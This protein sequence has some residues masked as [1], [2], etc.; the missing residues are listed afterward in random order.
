MKNR[1][2]AYISASLFFLVIGLLPYI[3]VRQDVMFL[4]PIRDILPEPLTPDETVIC[5]RFLNHFSDFA[6]YVALLL[7]MDSFNR[8]DTKDKILFIAAIALPFVLEAGQAF[9]IINGT[10][11]WLDILTYTLTLTIY[12]IMKKILINKKTQLQCAALVAFAGMALA[13][14]SSDKAT[15]KDSFRDSFRDSYNAVMDAYSYNMDEQI[16]PSDSIA[17][18]STTI[19]NQ[20]YID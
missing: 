6:W 12:L 11:D 2:G 10:F 4:L 16:S 15:F 3:L 18:N 1:S 17:D 14:S 19:N 9:H 13:C 5:R 8:N 7:F 20:N